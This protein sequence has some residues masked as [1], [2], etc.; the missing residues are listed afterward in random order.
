MKRAVDKLLDDTVALTDSHLKYVG[1]DLV[2][3][4]RSPS[5]LRRG[6]SIPVCASNLLLSKGAS[7]KVSKL[8]A[9]SALPNQG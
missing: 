9:Y 1:D 8:V 3:I 6:L 2:L 5:W 7:Q 4:T